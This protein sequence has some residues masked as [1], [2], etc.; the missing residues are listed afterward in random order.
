MI[1]N[2]FNVVYH[3]L[4]VSNFYLGIFIYKGKIM[5]KEMRK[6]IDTF[7]KFN[8]NESVTN[9]YKRD[10][11]D[12]DSPI[13]IE[14]ELE[15]GDYL[16][17]YKVE[18]HDDFGYQ[19]LELTSQDIEDVE[20]F[21]DEDEYEELLD[22]IIDDVKPKRYKEKEIST[23]WVAIDTRNGRV[24]HRSKNHIDRKFVAEWYDIPTSFIEIKIET[25]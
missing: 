15:Y 4:C 8:L 22:L 13:I 23:E 24:I 7:K 25:R 6:Y 1:N 12:D 20:D 14:G 3:L 9:E 16:F 17:D 2:R 5:S 18:Y 21:F 10:E 19:V 11:D